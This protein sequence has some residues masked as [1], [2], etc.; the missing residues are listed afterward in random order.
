MKQACSD[1]VRRDRARAGST[2]G[3]P[4]SESWRRVSTVRRAT[5]ILGAAS[6]GTCPQALAR[7]PG[8]S[9][10]FRDRTPGATRP[11][12]S[13]S[14]GSLAEIHLG[15]L[16]GCRRSVEQWIFLES[17]QACSD[18]GGELAPIRVVLLHPFVVAHPLDGDPVL[19]S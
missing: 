18:V 4:S 2:W 17:E 14:A 9:L 7:G 3:H 19:S 1:A 5:S 16:F 15:H 12:W 10:P 11:R 6:T 13:R 8:V